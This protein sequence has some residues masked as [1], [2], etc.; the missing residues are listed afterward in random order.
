MACDHQTAVDTFGM[1]RASDIG[2]V[3]IKLMDLAKYL[4]GTGHYK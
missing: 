2:D 4:S 3:Q 1:V